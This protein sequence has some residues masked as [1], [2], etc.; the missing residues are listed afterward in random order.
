M[1]MMLCLQK[2][3]DEVQ[4][5]LRWFAAKIDHLRALITVE[6]QDAK[7]EEEIFRSAGRTLLP[8]KEEQLANQLH[9]KHRRAASSSH[10][11]PQHIALLTAPTDTPLLL[12]LEGGPGCSRLLSNFLQL[13][14]YFLSC[15]SGNGAS[16]SRKPFTWNRR[17][18][19]L[20]HDNPLGTGSNVTPSTTYISQSQ[21]TIVEHVLAT[22]ESF[23]D[24]NPT[25][26]HARPFFLADESYAGEYVPAGA[27]RILATNTALSAHRRIGLRDVVIGNGLVHPVRL[28]AT[29]ADTTYF[30]GLINGRQ[31]RELEVL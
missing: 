16:L 17:F 23:F 27:S 25:D 15:H 8:Y 2:E 30:T 26:F 14:S 7:A 13:G 3:K 6:E 29:Y 18:G 12:W 9:R 21:P 24:A 11:P 31:Q 4:M 10:P 5:E 1:A 22:L 28:V 19:L 20:F